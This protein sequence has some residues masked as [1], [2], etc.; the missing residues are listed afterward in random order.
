MCTQQDRTEQNMNKNI[1]YFSF[2]LGDQLGGKWGREKEGG[3]SNLPLPATMLCCGGKKV[4]TR[5]AIKGFL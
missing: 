4:Y 1:L 3:R 2:I 5:Q